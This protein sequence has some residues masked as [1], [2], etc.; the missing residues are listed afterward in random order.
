MDATRQT[1]TTDRQNFQRVLEQTEAADITDSI[2]R[3]QMLQTQLDASYRITALVSQ[4]SLA[5]IL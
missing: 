3:I 2:V 5:K 1:H 4:L